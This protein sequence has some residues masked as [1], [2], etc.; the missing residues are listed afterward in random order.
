M[1]L[2]IERLPF[3]AMFTHELANHLL[4]ATSV[5]DQIGLH[6]CVCVAYGYIGNGG[7][8]TRDCL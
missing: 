2:Q 6:V 8:R 3:G 5:R 7:P 1:S 4:P